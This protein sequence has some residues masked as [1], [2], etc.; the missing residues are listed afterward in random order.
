MPMQ[1]AIIL[2]R[3]HPFMRPAMC[4]HFKSQWGFFEWKYLCLPCNS[5]LEYQNTDMLKGLFIRHQQQWNQTLWWSLFLQRRIY[6]GSEP[7][8]VHNFQLWYD[9]VLNR[10]LTGW[11]YLWMQDQFLVGPHPQSMSRSMRS[12]RRQSSGRDFNHWTCQ[13]IWVSLPRYRLLAN[14]KPKV[15]DKL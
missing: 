13:C 8:K 7:R 5:Y 15:C 14:P 12:D 10:S 2:E 6:L 1:I 9:Q 3:Q 11:G 4:K